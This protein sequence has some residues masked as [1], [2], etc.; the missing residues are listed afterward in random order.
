MGKFHGARSAVL[1]AIFCV[2]GL[3]AGNVVVVRPGFIRASF[4]WKM[5]LGMAAHKTT[6]CVPAV[7]ASVG[8]TCSLRAIRDPMFVH[9]AQRTGSLFPDYSPTFLWGGIS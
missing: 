4:V 9:Q 3:M 6:V 7:F 8:V 2:Q 5:V 1:W